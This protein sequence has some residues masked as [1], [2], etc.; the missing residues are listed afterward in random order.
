MILI[1]RPALAPLTT[2]RLGGNALAE[3]RLERM[4]D[5]P[6]LPET[7]KR[8]GGTPHVL[9]GGS[10][11]LIQDG[12]LPI[13]VVRPLIGAQTEPEVLRQEKGE[14]GAAD[15][16]LLRVGAGMR[17]PHLLAWCVRHGLAGLEGLVG[18]PG[19]VGGAIAM[20]A[21]AYGCST[22]P[23]VR[24]LTVFTPEQGVHTL[25][26]ENWKSAYRHFV[27]CEN[28]SWFIIL[29]AVFSLCVSSL[30]KLRA[31]YKNNLLRKKAGQPIYKHTAG[32][33]FKNPEGDAAGR[34]LDV[35]GMKG[36]R[37][38][39]LFFSPLH[40]NFLVHDAR[41]RT[42]GRCEDALALMDEAQKRVQEHFGIILE[43]EVRLW[44]CLS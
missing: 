12:E 25:S 1:D 30:E 26:P 36:V 24:S 14:A 13:V 17:I 31:L 6:R 38:G 42:C 40:A 5:L 9:G 7:L 20:N 16:I 32:C 4:E 23:L 37:R 33:V 15:R 28:C 19:H 2:L 29:S 3:V 8:L 34:L 10:N 21:G 41:S 18:I 22:A 44:P 35:V 43:K 27:L 11:L 39:A